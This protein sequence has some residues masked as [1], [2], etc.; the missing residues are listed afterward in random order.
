MGEMPTR[1]LMAVVKQ[2]KELYPENKFETRLV[3][4][5]PRS[6]K[7]ST[8]ALTN[9]TKA[10]FTCEHDSTRCHGGYSQ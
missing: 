8:A 2:L 6:E 10:A 3:Y 7:G 1:K 4:H 9:E 5:M